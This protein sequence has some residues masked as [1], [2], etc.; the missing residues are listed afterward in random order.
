M[1]VIKKLFGKMYSVYLKLYIVKVKKDSLNGKLFLLRA[2]STLGIILF[3]VSFNEFINYPN[4]TSELR[5]VSG[6]IVKVTSPSAKGGGFRTIVLK[7][8]GSDV[9]FR[10][11]AIRETAVLKDNIGKP[12]IIWSYSFK[13]MFFVTRNRVVEIEFEGVKIVK[14]WRGVEGGEPNIAVL[15]GVFIMIFP[16]FFIYKIITNNAD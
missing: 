3:W 15:L 7:S 10:D 14:D 13:D 8:D 11:Y 16:L 1:N 6:A 4:K 12:I 2:L 9:E 5:E